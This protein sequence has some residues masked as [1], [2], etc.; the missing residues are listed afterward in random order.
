MPTSKYNRSFAGKTNMHRICRHYN[1]IVCVQM[2]DVKA[3]SSTT[4]T[5][6][7]SRFG[8]VQNQ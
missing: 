8:A 3:V 7:Y 2:L 4:Q 1:H 6:Y 5:F